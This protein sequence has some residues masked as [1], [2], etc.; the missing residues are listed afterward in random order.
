[1]TAAKELKARWQTSA[2][3][4][5]LAQV[6]KGLTDNDPETLRRAVQHLPFVEEVASAID[7]RGIVLPLNG[8]SNRTA[9]PL[10]CDHAKID[11]NFSFCDLQGGS[12]ERA[13]LK[14]VKLIGCQLAGVSFVRANVAD[15]SMQKTNV[16]GC[17]FTY[18]KMRGTRLAEADCRNA[19]FEG[20]DMRSVWLARSDLRGADFR[21]VNMT[22]ST[23]GGVTFDE[24]TRFDGATVSVEGFDPPLLA[25]AR[26]QGAILNSTM[27]GFYLNF[28]DVTLIVLR[29][30]NRAGGHYSD[31]IRKLEALRP[32]VE[33]EASFDWSTA[34]AEQVSGAQWSALEEAM[35]KGLMNMSSLLS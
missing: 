12:F 24:T 4:D 6:I 33:A 21:G 20:A 23:F 13:T 10:V 17:A 14:R 7:L 32:K 9:L 16:S 28:V 11:W 22:S 3:I 31:T 30:M 27:D 2:G 26:A 35:H 8:F 5:A 34:L 15:A 1:M 29:D 18:A 19:R 25:Q